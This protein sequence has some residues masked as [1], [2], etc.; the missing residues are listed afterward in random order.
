MAELREITGRELLEQAKAGPI[1]LGD[2]KEYGSKRFV[3]ISP[4]DRLYLTV[5]GHGEDVRFAR[6]FRD[7]WSHIPEEHRDRMAGYWRSIER[8]PGL[9][10]ISITL[11]NLRSMRSRKENAVCEPD[12]TLLKFYAPVVDLM[13]PR[14]VRALVAHELAHVLQATNE[15]L[16]T[17]ERP[18]CIT[19]E[20]ISDMAANSGVSFEEMKAR[21]LHQFDPVER[22]ADKIA[23]RWGFSVRGMDRWLEKNIDWAKLPD[24]AYC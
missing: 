9:L 4:S 10:G 6:I 19:D 15:T 13:P 23:G 24:P 5:L 3:P 22:D 20:D 7:A 21:V 16:V 12:G 18:N 8:I 14:H 11:E 1:D 2:L 17:S